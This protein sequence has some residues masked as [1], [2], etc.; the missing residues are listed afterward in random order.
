M[1]PIAD[2]TTTA[3]TAF[4]GK[5]IRQRVRCASSACPGSGVCCSRR[6][7]FLAVLWMVMLLISEESLVGV[8]SFAQKKQH[9]CRGAENATRKR[10]LDDDGGDDDDQEDGV[11]ALLVVSLY[12]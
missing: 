2:M 7:W 1:P 10:M 11:G 5:G 4:G 8:V 12:K 6:H 9:V 3:S